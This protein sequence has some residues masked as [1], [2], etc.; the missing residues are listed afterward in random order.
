MSEN[1]LITMDQVFEWFKESVSDQEGRLVVSIHINDCE[2][3]S[4]NVDAEKIGTLKE[5]YVNARS[6]GVYKTAIVNVPLLI[7]YKLD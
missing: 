6:E 7:V 5:N 3:L 4:P 1:N 2:I